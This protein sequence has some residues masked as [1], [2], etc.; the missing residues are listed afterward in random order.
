MRIGSLVSGALVCA[1]TVGGFAGSAL[2]DPTGVWLTE[3]GTAHVKIYPCGD[4]ER[5][6]EIVWLK[7]PLGKDGKPRRDELNE[8]ESLRDR[9]LLGIQVLFD[10]EDEGDGEWGD[11]EVYNS[12]DGETYD[13]EMEEVDANTIKVSGC[14]LFFCKTETW[15]RVE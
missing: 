12:K 1:L 3:P 8:D 5:C 11:G 2:A 9:Q 15:T 7:R 14:V 6:G 13:A 10:L 4:G